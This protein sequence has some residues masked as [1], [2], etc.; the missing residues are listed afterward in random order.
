[1]LKRSKMKNALSSNTSTRTPDVAQLQ[2]V[3]PSRPSSP[4]RVEIE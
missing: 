4:K 1:M 3:P 2:S